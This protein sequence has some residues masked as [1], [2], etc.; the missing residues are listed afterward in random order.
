LDDVCT[1]VDVVTLICGVFLLVINRSYRQL[2]SYP[3]AVQRR[4]RADVV[5]GRVA[6]RAFFLSTCRRINKCIVYYARKQYPICRETHASYECLMF[7]LGIRSP[8]M[9]WCARRSRRS[10][11]DI[12][13]SDA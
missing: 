1:P 2:L 12:L 9:R 10:Y 6:S 13:T 5:Y 3:F 7:C 4:D 11:F 8:G